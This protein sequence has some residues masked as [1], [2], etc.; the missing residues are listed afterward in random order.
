MGS[1]TT[2]VTAMRNLRCWL[3]GHEWVPT[4]LRR[5]DAFEHRARMAYCPRCETTMAFVD[6]DEEGDHDE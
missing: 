6:G 1:P 2:E 5:V 4:H 3:F